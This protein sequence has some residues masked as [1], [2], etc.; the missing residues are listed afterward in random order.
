M[1]RHLAIVPWRHCPNR[2]SGSLRRAVRSAN[3]RFREVHPGDHIHGLARLLL[4]SRRIPAQTA[5]PLPVQELNQ[6][7]TEPELVSDGRV[8][9]GQ[10]SPGGLIE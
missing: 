7:D 8:E 6:A 4:R 1:I 9:W 3:L 2:D 5:I 10:A